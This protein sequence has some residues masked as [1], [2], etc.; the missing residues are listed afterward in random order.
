MTIYPMNQKTVKL[1]LCQDR[2]SQPMVVDPSFRAFDATL[3]MTKSWRGFASK[4]NS[5]DPLGSLAT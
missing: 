2:Y 5:G 1:M 3:P 4:D